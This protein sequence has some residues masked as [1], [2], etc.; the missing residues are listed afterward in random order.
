MN[1]DERERRFVQAVRERRSGMYRVA[2]S[3]LRRP[4]DAEDAVSAAVETAWNHLDRI[5]EL[6][7][8][9]SYLMRCTV[10]SCYGALRRSRRETPVEDMVPLLPSAG[11]TPGLW[12]YLDSLPEKYRLPL[13]LRYSE[14]MG[15][16]EVAKA[17]RL[18]RSGASS[19]IR[20]G[21]RILK[22]QMN[23]EVSGRE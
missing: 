1:R 18:T 15:V 20:R 7:A 14:E 2:L 22:Q 17:L 13:I 4:Q 23:G 12:E 10:N 21:L 8:L 3:M 9:P 6:D 19:R 5:R 11:D 16:A